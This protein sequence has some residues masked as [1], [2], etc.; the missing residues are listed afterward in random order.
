[1]RFWRRYLLL[2][3]GDRVKRIDTDVARRPLAV[4][5]ILHTAMRAQ[6]LTSLKVHRLVG[7]TPHRCS[8][9]KEDEDEGDRGTRRRER[10][11]DFVLL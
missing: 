3:L 2:R 6:V 9:R 4:E 1:M 5:C 8:K 10:E 7:S 11:K